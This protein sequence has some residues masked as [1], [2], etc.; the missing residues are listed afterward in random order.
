MKETLSERQDLDFRDTIL[1]FSKPKIDSFIF[2]FIFVMFENQLKG[3]ILRSN[4]IEKF[5]WLK[6]IPIEI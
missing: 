5:F 2:G 4:K 6:K 3:Y 1:S